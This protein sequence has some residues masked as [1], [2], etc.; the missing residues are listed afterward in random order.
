[1]VAL[2]ERVVLSEEAAVLLAAAALLEDMTGL[3]RLLPIDP[4]AGVA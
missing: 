4:R 1:M 2:D 3:A